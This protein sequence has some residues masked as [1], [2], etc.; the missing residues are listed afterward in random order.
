MGFVALVLVV[1]QG[2]LGGMTVLFFLPPPIS[3]IHG[4]L[5]QTFFLSTIFIAYSLS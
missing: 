1:I 5:A 3:I 2:L 4:I